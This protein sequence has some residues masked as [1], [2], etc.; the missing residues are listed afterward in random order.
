MSAPGNKPKFDSQ[1]LLICLGIYLTITILVM[2]FMPG[3]AVMLLVL[4]LVAM[5]AYSGWLMSKGIPGNMPKKPKDDFAGRIQLRFQDCQD[6][7][8]RFRTEAEQ[9]R[10]SISTLREDL[11]RSSAAGEDER[12][13]AENVIKELEAEFNL[14]HAKAS[15]FADCSAKLKVLLNRY[16]LQESISARKRE[17]ETLRSTN[18]D[19]EAALEETRYHLERDTIEL[20]TIAELSKEAFVS[21]KAEQAEELRVRLEKLRSRL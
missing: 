13:R 20:D 1:T 14:R 9:I 15:F 21:F 10:N 7:E 4:G 17:L 11:E 2:R 6:K 18:F 8:E 16:Q 19:D 5:L 12:A 3:L